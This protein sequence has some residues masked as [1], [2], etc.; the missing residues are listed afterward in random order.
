MSQAQ[1]I[2]P[3]TVRVVGKRMGSGLTL[4]FIGLAAVAGFA[5]ACLWPVALV[6]WA[7]WAFWDGSATS[8]A[9]ARPSR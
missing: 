8:Q 9:W 4:A 2:L 3:P 5:V 6:G 7:L 1:L